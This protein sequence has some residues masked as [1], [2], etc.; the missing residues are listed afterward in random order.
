MPNIAQV[1]RLIVS[2]SA[3]NDL[4]ALVKKKL[5]GMGEEFLLE[6]IGG[7]MG[8]AQRISQA[9]ATGGVS[10]LQHLGEDAIRQ[11]I[12]APLPHSALLHKI[13]DVFRG[14]ARQG[15]R[16]SGLWSHSDWATSRN[17]WL[18]NHWRHDWR[19]QP[20]DA[21]GRWVPGRLNYIAQSLQY[22]GMKLGRRRL[23]R[24]RQRLLSRRM[25]RRAV[26]NAM[27]GMQNGD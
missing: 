8:T 5:E 4:E 6:F 21:R 19:S 2:F 13:Q 14:R 10:E 9:V 16:R 26:R 3:S 22:Q 7:P 17:D 25:A 12:P 11:A 1:A 20:R 27:K 18:D 24:R 23:R 15:G